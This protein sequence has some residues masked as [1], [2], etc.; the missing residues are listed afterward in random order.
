MNAE[1]TI[2]ENGTVRPAHP[3]IT[4]E[5]Q[6]AMEWH[7]H[8]YSGFFEIA[9]ASAITIEQIICQEVGLGKSSGRHWSIS[10]GCVESM[11]TATDN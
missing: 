9:D 7:P 3:I 10:A 8:G 5:V 11:P 2:G 6:K 1:K 4:R